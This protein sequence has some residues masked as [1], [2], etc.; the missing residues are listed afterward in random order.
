M[1][2]KNNSTSEKNR[3]LFL[4]LC[5]RNISIYEDTII[6]SNV[7]FTS[8]SLVKHKIIENIDCVVKSMDPNIFVQQDPNNVD[9]N[10]FALIYLYNQTS[11]MV[12]SG[13]FS[14]FRTLTDEG[15][16]LFSFVK[17]LMQK[18]VEIGEWSE[19]RRVEELKALEKEIKSVG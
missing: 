4:E 10:F 16:S 14:M 3:K 1:F 6:K 17:Y 9:Y 15:Q 2:F 5:H 12:A 7:L 11:D 13:E 18:L 19:E 8:F